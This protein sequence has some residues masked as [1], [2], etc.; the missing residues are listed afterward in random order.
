MG[1]L[2]PQIRP[3]K[4]SNEEGDIIA[5]NNLLL[6]FYLSDPIGHCYAGSCSILNSVSP[7]SSGDKL[8]D[9]FL[10]DQHKKG[11]DPHWFSYSSLIFTNLHFFPLLPVGMSPQLRDVTALASCCG[12][13]ATRAP[14]SPPAAEAARASWV[15][16]ARPA[17]NVAPRHDCHAPL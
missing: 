7:A 1:A 16:A 12:D 11:W 2:I 6:F 15:I 17:H 9:Q 10:E 13:L 3:I 5:K 8:H 14:P 4:H